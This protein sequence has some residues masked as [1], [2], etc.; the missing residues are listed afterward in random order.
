MKES[1]YM[2]SGGNECWAFF[3]HNMEN[4]VGGME[5]HAKYFFLNEQHTNFMSQLTPG[6]ISIEREGTDKPS[7]SFYILEKMY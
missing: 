4:A 1:E 2:N 3:V 5:T 7:R 6:I